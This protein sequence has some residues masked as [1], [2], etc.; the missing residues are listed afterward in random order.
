[1]SNGE[2]EVHRP[3][4]RRRGTEKS[5]IGSDDMA[6]NSD[7]SYENYLLVLTQ[8]MLSIMIWISSGNTTSEGTA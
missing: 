3:T 7:A 6:M 5:G 4:Q 8:S 1:M 2:P